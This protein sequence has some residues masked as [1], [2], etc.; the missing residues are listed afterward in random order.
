[1]WSLLSAILLCTLLLILYFIANLLESQGQLALSQQQAVSLNEAT[2]VEV[3]ALAHDLGLRPLVW[4]Y[5]NTPWEQPLASMYRHIPWLQ[6]NMEA[7]AF[8]IVLALLVGLTLSMIRAYVHRLCTRI[9]FDVMT[10]LRR[11]LHRQSLRLGP[12][13][14]EDRSGDNVLKLFSTDV[15]HV[16]ATVS[17]RVFR[18][19]QY[20]LELAVLIL[21]ALLIDWRVAGQCLIPLGFCWFLFQR[22]QKRYRASRAMSESRAEADL[23][24]LAEGFRKTRLVRGYGMESYEHEHFQS[25]LNHYRDNALAAERSHRWYRWTCRGLMLIC[26]AVLLFFCGIK[27]LNQNGVQNS[28]HLSEFSLMLLLFGLMFPPLNSLSELAEQRTN[29][30][31]A[32]DRIYRFLNR[33]PEVSQAVGAKFLEPLSKSIQYESIRYT[34]PNSTILLDGIDLKLNAGET[35][36]VVSHDPQEARALVYLLMRFIEPNKGRILFDGEDIAWATLESLRA[37]AIYVGGTDPFFTGTVLENITC[38]RT[39]YSLQDATEA[40]KKTHAHHFILKLPQ[41]YE[42]QLGEHG[43][44]LNEGQAFRLGLARAILRNPA[45]LIIEEPECGLDADTK[46]MLDDTYQRICR[47][48]TVIFLPARLS[49]LKRAD[50]IVLMN[51]GKI[52]A[53]GKH[54]VLVKASALYRHWEYLHFNEFRNE[55]VPG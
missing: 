30:S 28:F 16:G 38:G 11:M 44:L 49:T 18:L 20:P 8:L 55:P 24:H 45:L 2:G 4:R 34:G 9:G 50:R 29:A 40:A 37:E 3:P 35:T 10:R 12:G 41:G 33:I 52:E 22:S 19:T 53:I 21:L 54:S 6:S 13:D 17:R 32:A 5:L 15:D 48:R 51:R 43:N 25:H 31:T 7:L 1:M 23:R 14:L 26:V 27:V 36:A 42:T 46:S 39:E 47:D